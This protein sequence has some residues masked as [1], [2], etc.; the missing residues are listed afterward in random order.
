MLRRHGKQGGRHMEQRALGSTGLSVSVMG[1]GCGAVGGLMVRGAAADQERAVARAVELGISYFDTAPSYGEGASESNLGRVLA[2]LRPA[3]VLGTKFHVRPGPAAEIEA[4]IAASLEA[5]LRRLGR[6]YVDLLQLHNPIGAGG[7]AALPP[8]LVF[9]H[10]VPALQRLRAQGKFGFAGFTAI[11]DTAALQRVLADAGLASAQVQYN[12]LNPSAGRAVAAGY[13]GQ[14][15]GDLLGRARAAG[16][17]CIGIRVLAGGALSASEARHPIGVPR[18]E[19]IGSGADYRTDVRRAQPFAAL[20]REAGLAGPTELAIRFAIAHPA[21]GTAL[22][23]L[24]TLE[25]LELA[26]AAALRG[27]LPDD[28]LRRIA[29]VQDGFAGE[30]R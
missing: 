13:P 15:Y 30:P 26:A 3:I 5:S 9:E 6:E 2:R 29:A 1:F 23:G 20:A 18:V 25:H 10:V 16:V 24:S 21:L 27:P 19:P 22:V 12:L 11:G 7:G 14:D 28:L 17:G 8:E 4:G